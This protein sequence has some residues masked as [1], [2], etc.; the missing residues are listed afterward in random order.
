VYEI[1]SVANII[2]GIIVIPH[3]RRAAEYWELLFAEPATE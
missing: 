2:G 3:R 1:L